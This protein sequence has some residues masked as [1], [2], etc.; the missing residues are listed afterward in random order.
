ML[1]NI[2]NIFIYICSIS[3]STLFVNRQNILSNILHTLDIDFTIVFMLLCWYM[4]VTK[5]H[6][7]LFQRKMNRVVLAEKAKVSENWLSK[8]YYGKLNTMHVP[9]MQRV[10]DVLDVKLS[11]IIE[12]VP[13]NEKEGNT[14][15]FDGKGT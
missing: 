6:D 13:G 1:I 9:S 4:I 8:L 3:N 15:G 10:C 11:D 7:V 5:L 14:E 2:F 12:I